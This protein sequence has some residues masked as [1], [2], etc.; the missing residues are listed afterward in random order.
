MDEPLVMGR[1]LP[2]PSIMHI[3][4]SPALSSN[5][6]AGFDCMHAFRKGCVTA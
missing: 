2:G 4:D 6:L 5:E 3:R 1:D